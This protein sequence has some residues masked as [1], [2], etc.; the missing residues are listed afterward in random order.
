MIDNAVA[1]GYLLNV[2][3]GICCIL[4]VLVAVVLLRFFVKV[5]KAVVK[6]H[7]NRTHKFVHPLPSPSEITIFSQWEHQ[8]GNQ[9]APQPGAEGRKS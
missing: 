4:L 1:I 7:C 9:A 5:I 3:D 6:P 2:L 8:A